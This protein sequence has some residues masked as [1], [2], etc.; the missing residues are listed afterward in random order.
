MDE[1]YFVSYQ[2]MAEKLCLYLNN[3]FKLE[4]VYPIIDSSKFID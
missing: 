4:V 2:N 3:K 1:N